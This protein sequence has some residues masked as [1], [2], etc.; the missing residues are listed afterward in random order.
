MASLGGTYLSIPEY[1]KEDK[2]GVAWEII[3]YLSTSPSAQLTTF[4]TIDAYPAL[5]SVYDD[6]I[7]DEGLAYFG[8]Q[9][10]RKIYADVAENIPSNTVS[11]YD[12]LILSIWNSTVTSVLTGETG[13]M[14]GYDKAKQQVLAT[15]Q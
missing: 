12:A 11:E 9:K 8:G 1:V 2:K 5:T 13:M 15:I 10:V 7:M 4:N 6:P 3:K 14:E